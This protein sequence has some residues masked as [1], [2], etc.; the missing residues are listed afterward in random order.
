M[1]IDGPGGQ[2]DPA[3][4]GRRD[5]PAADYELVRQLAHDLCQPVA[6]I[7]ALAYATSAEAQA[8]VLQRLRQ[9]GEQAVRLS[10]LIDDLLAG[11]RT[12]PGPNRDR[13]EIHELV[14]DV[15]ESQ[16]LTYPGRITL[17]QAGDN[18]CYVLAS[19]TRLRRALGNVVGNATR[20]AG[21]DGSVQL[22]QRTAD[23]FEVIEIADS[24]PGFGQVAL[25]HGIGLR[26]TER[27]LAECGGHLDIERRAPGQT[28]VR[29]WL[30]VAFEPCGR[31][32][33]R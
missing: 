8:P 31:A 32:G 5:Y 2:R 22:T 9:I 13:T 3:W 30:P 29:L 19:A 25:V 10:E 17:H 20:A 12:A 21:A 15:V 1:K 33:S 18:A 16:R 23:D 14:R 7:R 11:P 4:P 24:G 28:L 26:I 27:V 6:A